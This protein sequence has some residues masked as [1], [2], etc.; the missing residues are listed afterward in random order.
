[1]LF[2]CLERPVMF[3]LLSLPFLVLAFVLAGEL[4]GQEL[5]D[6][7]CLISG[8]T[9]SAKV[10]TKY[11]DADLY[12][13]SPAFVEAYKKDPAA[14]S[15]KANHQLALTGQYVQKSCPITGKPISSKIKSTV[16]AVEVAFAD[17][18][19]KKK[20]DS[21]RKLQDK[22]ALIFADKPFEKAFAKKP[23]L[24]LTNVNCFMIPKRKVKDSKVVAHRGGKVFFCCPNCVSK[25]QKDTKKYDAQGN[26]QLVQ[27]GQ[28]KQS[29]CPIS[30]GEV[31]EDHFSEVD[32]IK[33]FFCC[34]RCKAKVDT[35]ATDEAKREL[36]FGSKRFEKT[37]TK[38]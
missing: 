28:F 22:V 20:V 23:A 8:K 10:A 18:A 38:N 21:A 3:K 9:A 19:A 5:T 12:F 7:K 29:Q 34:E 24:D 26:V 2:L 11:R 25:F 17:E 35:A 6:V 36:V 13:S 14:Y 30:G 37:F 32:G 1:M 15:T 16:G 33:V 27:T 31:S 4:S